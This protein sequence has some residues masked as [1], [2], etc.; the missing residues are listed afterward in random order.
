[1]AFSDGF[2]VWY[3]VFVFTQVL[4]VF[5]ISYFFKRVSNLFSV[6]TILFWISYQYPILFYLDIIEFQ[7][8]ITLVAEKYVESAFYYSMLFKLSFDFAYVGWMKLRKSKPSF[9][10]G[11]GLNINFSRKFKISSSWIFFV[12]VVA[13]TC[14]ILGL[15]GNLLALFAPPSRFFGEE[16]LLNIYKI[17]SLLALLMVL[18]RHYNYRKNHILL[19]VALILA[20]AYSMAIFSRAVVIP[21]ALYFVMRF[22]YSSSGWKQ[23][24]TIVVTGIVYFNAIYGRGAELGIINFFASIIELIPVIP[25]LTSFVMATVSGQATLTLTLSGVEEGQ[26][27]L[28]TNVTQFL[29]YISPIPS[30]LLDTS[31]FYAYQSL[32]PHFGFPIGINTDLV[33]ESIL[34][35]GSGYFCFGAALGL[36]FSFVDGRLDKAKVYHLL[37][38]ACCV[39]SGLS[40]VASIRA[41]SR[42]IIYAFVFM[43]GWKFAAFLTSI[44]RKNGESRKI[45]S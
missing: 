20:L 25:D 31:K 10:N 27:R 15:K 34:W 18:Y 42:F 11:H 38:F 21:F 3:F 45:C 8:N 40:S 16:T 36:L 41:A 9:N 19:F 1:M 2:E 44:A 26:I 37:F 43:W 13:G 14:L 12:L 32:T 28:P 17:F 24:L 30:F 5:Y 7:A 22:I 39:F 4:L 23:F 35:F 6:M 33:G 29:L